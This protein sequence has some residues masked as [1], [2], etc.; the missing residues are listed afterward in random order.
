VGGDR[1]PLLYIRVFSQLTCM[2]CW[3]QFCLV[4]WC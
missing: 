4:D 2:L 3:N 1:L